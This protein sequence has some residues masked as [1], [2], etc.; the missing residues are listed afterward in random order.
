MRD[1][2]GLAGKVLEKIPNKYL[3]VIVSSKRA[4]ALNDGSRP[5]I[6]TSAVKPTTVAMEEVAAGYV[7]P[8]TE[9]PAVEAAEKNEAELLPSPDDKPK[10]SAKT[11][12][13]TT[14]EEK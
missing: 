14:A 10:A 6:K 7:V 12:T 11:K 8:D 13:K 1:D 2:T 4:K 9:R 3:A 5:L